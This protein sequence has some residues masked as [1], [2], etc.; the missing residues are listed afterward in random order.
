MAR[1]FSSLS[2]ARQLSDLVKRFPTRS[3]RFSNI[4]TDCLRDPSWDLQ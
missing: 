4:S 2:D 1:I 3:C